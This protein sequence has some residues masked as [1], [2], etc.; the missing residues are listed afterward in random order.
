MN[1]PDLGTPV[2]GKRGDITFTQILSTREV[3]RLLGENIQELGLLSFTFLE[4]FSIIFDLQTFKLV[5]VYKVIHL[6][7]CIKYIIFS[8]KHAMKHA[9][10]FCLSNKRKLRL[11]EMSDLTKVTGLVSS[12]AGMRPGTLDI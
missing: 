3:C 9:A 5:I 8:L 10:Y 2:A 12:R 1:Q 4:I 11:K 7:L 6:L